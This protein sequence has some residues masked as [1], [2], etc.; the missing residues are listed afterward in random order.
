LLAPALIDCST[1]LVRVATPHK[2]R[3]AGARLSVGHGRARRSRRAAH[4]R[5]AARA[6]A[7][8]EYFTHDPGYHL[9]NEVI[10][11][12][13]SPSGEEERTVQRKDAPPF[14]PTKAF[15]LGPIGFTPV[16]EMEVDKRSADP[17]K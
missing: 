4:L 11:S 14:A 8:Q 13:G 16:Q 12:T 15:S 6:C 3:S 2:R 7:A 5:I 9:E 1:D 17:N 10:K